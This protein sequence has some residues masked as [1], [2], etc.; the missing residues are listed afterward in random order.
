LL[1]TVLHIYA[2]IDEAASVL[3]VPEV[4]AGLAFRLWFS[5]AWRSSHPASD[6]EDAAL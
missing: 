4:V 2:S 6:G 1:P 3:R 5:S